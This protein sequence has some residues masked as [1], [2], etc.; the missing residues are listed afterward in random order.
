MT[1]TILD[2]IAVYSSA[3]QLMRLF[4]VPDPTSDNLRALPGK[5]LQRDW[6]DNM[7][8]A[9]PFE[10]VDWAL[11]PFD[12]DYVDDWIDALAPGDFESPEELEN[13]F[14]W[15]ALPRDLSYTVV[16]CT[17]RSE[18]DDARHHPTK[19]LKRQCGD[20]RTGD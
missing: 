3:E 12:Q 1:S 6:Y 5:F 19:F 18:A 15:L 11:E 14:P 8:K 10:L 13:A 16:N 20:R 4:L 9:S 17:W 2:H 7:T